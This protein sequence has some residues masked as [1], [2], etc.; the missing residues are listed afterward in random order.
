MIEY[1]APKEIQLKQL[2]KLL[3]TTQPIVAKRL[4]YNLYKEGF[5][6]RSYYDWLQSEARHYYKI[7]FTD[8]VKLNGDR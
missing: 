5:F 4:F 3:S 7:D 1:Y 8:W 6:K 2:H